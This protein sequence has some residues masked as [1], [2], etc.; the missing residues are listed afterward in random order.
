MEN[1]DKQQKYHRISSNHPIYTYKPISFY[2]NGPK[3]EKND[4]EEEE[5]SYSIND[6][7]IKVLKERK[8]QEKN[9]VIKTNI[10]EDDN[11]NKNE[12]NNKDSENVIEQDTKIKEIPKKK[13]K[14]IKKKKIKK[15][16]KNTSINIP[17]TDIKKEEEEEDIPNKFYE[18]IKNDNEGDLVKT[19][20][21]TD[22]NKNNENEKK[23]EEKDCGRKSQN[24][25]HDTINI[26]S[27]PD[28]FGFEV[29]EDEYITSG[30][31]NDFLFDEAEKNIKDIKPKRKVQVRK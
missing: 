9:K 7:K 21:L 28:F 2:S 13:K 20:S 26:L 10:T 3:Q 1:K 22:L 4:D 14:I 23:N 27:T 8:S 19:K 18:F 15:E 25:M 5:F 31:K 17:I 6:K 16:I 11:S 30:N 29:D 12:K 24:A